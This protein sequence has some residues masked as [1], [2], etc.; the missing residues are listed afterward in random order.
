MIQ[1]A[2]ERRIG[3]RLDET[4]IDVLADYQAILGAK[5]GT[6]INLSQAVRAAILAAHALEAAKAQQQA[7]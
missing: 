3:V 6:P 7:A 2:N 5:L 1:R 4:S